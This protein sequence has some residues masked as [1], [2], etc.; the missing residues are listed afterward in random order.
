MAISPLT[1]IIFVNQNMN[2]AASVQNM[3]FNRYDVQQ[4]AAQA[5]VNEKEKVIEETR[6]AEEAM[7]V[8][9]D[10]EHERQEAQE[11]EEEREKAARPHPKK[12]R[13]KGFTLDDEG[14][15]HIDIHV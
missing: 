6:P 13:D 2:V 12:S 1:N 5:L 14:N 11:R 8:D 9:P 7:A 4:A 10:R 3:Q 15:P